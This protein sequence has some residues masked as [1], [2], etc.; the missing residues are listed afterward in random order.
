M[1]STIQYGI[2]AY[3]DAGYAIC[4][5]AVSNLWPRRWFPQK[6]GARVKPGAP[7]YTGDYKDAFGNRMS[8][9]AV[10]DPLVTGRRP[11]LLYDRATGY[12]I[13]RFDKKTREITLEC[14]PRFADP[15]SLEGQPYPGWPI[16]IS[17][18]DNYGRAAKAYL[19]T[20]K[21]QGMTDPVVQVVEEKTGDI[22]YTVRAKGGSFRPKVFSPGAYTIR[23]GEPGTEEWKTLRHVAALPP[24]GQGQ[25]IVEFK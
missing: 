23:C 17:Q 20:L 7:R 19:P 25:K 13:I 4:I 12:A 14:W 10:A 6:P 18:F 21:F 15:N 8:V 22:V 2:D 1:P 5:P 9:A 16:T 11:A 3:G 24:G